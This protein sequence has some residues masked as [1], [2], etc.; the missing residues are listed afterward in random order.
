MKSGMSP[1]G[2]P[3]IRYSRHKS[4][5]SS[6]PG[7]ATAAHPDGFS[8]AELAIS[9]VEGCVKD[10]CLMGFRGADIKA[11]KTCRQVEGELDTV[12]SQKYYPIC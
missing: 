11:L 9:G 6:I 1:S 8:E 7:P 3:A 4:T 12:L 5:S 10:P 2:R